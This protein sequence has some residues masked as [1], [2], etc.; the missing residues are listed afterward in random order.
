I[1][2]I[3]IP[4][5]GLV[6]PNATGMIDNSQYTW[7][8]L[9]ICYAYFT[10]I[11]YAIWQGNRFLLFRLRPRFSWLNQPVQKVLALVVSN[12][13]YTI[14]IAV[15]LTVLW[16]AFARHS[17]TDWDVIF[18]A[19]ALC[20]ICVVFITHTYE[21]VFLIRSWET[22]RVKS[23]KLEKERARA[24]LDALKNQI[25][26]HF[27][28]N[29]LNTL[30]H[31]IAEDSAKAQQFNDH[32]ADVYR[33]I[34]SNKDRNLVFLKE[35][36]TFLEHYFEL[37]KIR[38][39]NAVRLDVQLSVKDLDFFLLPPISLQILLENAIKHNEFSEESPLTLKVWL[40][41]DVIH[42]SN[43]R[44]PKRGSLRSSKVGLKNLG[45]RYKA[46]TEKEIHIQQTNGSFEVELPILRVG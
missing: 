9:W 4:F 1:R 28:F 18:K 42:I 20:V 29:S 32:L 8:E 44:R 33:Y 10:F 5:F 22:D 37:L 46:I 38:F 30:S 15:G 21:T 45:E 31:L 35:E 24:E 26:P 27:I 3:F 11:A 40:E 14:P 41:G 25:D 12:V 23:E 2:L 39:G 19:T 43:E 36:L 7:W 13:F 34:L 17:E 6:I 16:Y